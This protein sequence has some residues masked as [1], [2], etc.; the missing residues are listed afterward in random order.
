MTAPMPAET[1][2]A[3][4]HASLKLL[5]YVRGYVKAGDCNHKSIIKT[6]NRQVVHH[7]QEQPR[8]SID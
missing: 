5:D 3:K 4:S 2:I 1:R 7:N 8:V 6:L